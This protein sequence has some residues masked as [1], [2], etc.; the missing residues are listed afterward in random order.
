MCPELVAPTQSHTYTSACICALSWWRPPKSDWPASMPASMH[1]CTYAMCAHQVGLAAVRPALRPVPCTVRPALG[2]RGADRR[3]RVQACRWPAAAR[4]PSRWGAV[5]ACTLVGRLYPAPCTL[6]LRAARP[7]AAAGGARGRPVPCTHAT[8]GWPARRRARRWA[9]GAGLC[10]S[11]G[12]NDR[13]HSGRRRERRRG[14]P[15]KRLG[16]GGE[17][18]SLLASRMEPLLTVDAR[19]GTLEHVL[20]D[21][22][23][24]LRED[25]HVSR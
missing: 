23:V 11:C 13:E 12:R 8:R 24:P 3:Y 17:R 22:R 14:A 20:L 1:A 10:L 2:P 4:R 21:L 7:L 18:G 15:S 19:C 25:L 16:E 5:G 9:R 6:G